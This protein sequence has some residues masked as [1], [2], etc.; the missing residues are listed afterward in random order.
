MKLLSFLS[1]TL[2][3][4]F[5]YS[6]DG[7]QVRGS[8]VTATDNRKVSDF[9]ELEVKGSMDVYFTDGPL[10]EAVIEAD[11]NILPYIELVNE[12]DKLI[13]RTKKNH[14]FSTHDDIKITLSAPD[15]RAISLSGSGNI[16]VTNTLENDDAVKLN[17]SGSGDITALVH[18]PEVKVNVTGSGNIKVGGETRDLDLNVAGSGNFEGKELM[19]ESASVNVAGSGDAELHASVKLDVK[20]VGSGNVEYHGNPEVVSKI[21]G[22]GGLSKKD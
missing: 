5:L 19:A 3:A 15:V 12:G 18:S 6:C 4:V 10:Q 2:L 7:R 1:L 8:G 16:K 21:M 14:Q 22:S 20:V 13:I 9:Q 17:I 11:D